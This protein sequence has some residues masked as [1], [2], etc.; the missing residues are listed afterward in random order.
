MPRGS[1]IMNQVRGS[2]I[3]DHGGRIMIQVQAY[4]VTVRGSWFTVRG[5]RA[6][7]KYSEVLMNGTG[8]NGALSRRGGLKRGVFMVLLK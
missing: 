8:F 7:F 3:T 4:C 1:R 2:R 5:S 6:W